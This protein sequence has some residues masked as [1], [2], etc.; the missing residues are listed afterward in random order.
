MKKT[1]L[2][3][4]IVFVNLFFLSVLSA[5]SLDILN[6]CYRMHT[7]LGLL[8]LFDKFTPLSLWNL[9]PIPGNILCSELYFVW[10]YPFQFFLQWIFAEYILFYPFICNPLLVVHS[11]NL[12]LLILL[13]RKFRPFT[14]NMII[15]MVE[16]KTATLIPVFY[17]PHLFFVP[18]FFSYFCLGVGVSWAFYNTS[19]YLHYYLLVILRFLLLCF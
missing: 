5:F 15:A 14:F 2:K 11:G 9:P 18:F 7:H 6:L 4:P 3:L 10:C 19:V 1:L 12:C 17:L 13:I 16:F 8:Y